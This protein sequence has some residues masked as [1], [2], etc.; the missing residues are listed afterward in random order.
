LQDPDH[1]GG[2]VALCQS[3]EVTE[4][5]CRARAGS[6]GRR[7]GD[8]YASGRERSGEEAVNV[9]SDAAAVPLFVTVAV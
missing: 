2:R 1:D 7:S 6:N 4:H 8:E 3:A 5:C 9:T